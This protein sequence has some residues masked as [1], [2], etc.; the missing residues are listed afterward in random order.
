M[1]LMIVRGAG[2][3]RPSNQSLHC[4]IQ[5]SIFPAFKEN[6]E[7][8]GVAVSHLCHGFR[9]S[10]CLIAADRKEMKYTYLLLAFGFL[11]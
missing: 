10:F 3:D 7:L 2:S 6:P 1:K 8:S 4:A 5:I 11:L 9:S